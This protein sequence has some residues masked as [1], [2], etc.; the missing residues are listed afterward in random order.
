M[1]N[2]EIIKY[3]MGVSKKDF[4]KLEVTSTSVIPINPKYEFLDIR[5]LMIK[6]R[7]DIFIEY[8]LDTANKLDY[9]FDL[10]FG[11]KVYQ[12]LN[13]DIG[14]TNRVATNN[15]IWRYLS[16]S[17]IPD[18]VHSRW[19]F[20]EAHFYSTPRRIWLKTIW[21]YINLSWSEN[22]EITYD[23]LKDNTTDTI[24]QMVERPGIG[25]YTDVYREIMSQYANVSDPSRE[26]FRR[27][28]KINTA[29]L[30]TTSPELVG[31]GIKSYVTEL[32]DMVVD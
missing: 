12:I 1:I 16:I 28:L 13:N 9:K 23:L 4:D 22:E 31:G 30:R 21:W 26:I 2:W 6:A 7:D 17:V 18:I 15:D 29:R 3:D 32:F 19:Q 25:Y 24:L 14:F 5:E 11:L 8:K 27:I 10:L 20:N